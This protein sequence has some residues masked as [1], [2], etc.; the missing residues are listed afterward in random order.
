MFIKTIF[1]Q[2]N[3]GALSEWGDMQLFQ[4][5]SAWWSSLLDR[6]AVPCAL[7]TTWTMRRTGSSRTWEDAISD[8]SMPLV[9][10][11]IDS[12]HFHYRW[13]QVDSAANTYYSL[14][15]LTRSD[16]R[17]GSACPFV[18]DRLCRSGTPPQLQC[19]PQ[20]K[21]VSPRNQRLQQQVKQLLTAGISCHFTNETRCGHVQ[22]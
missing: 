21:Q 20:R 12:L 2:Y 4:T 6:P 22:S 14:S 15:S 3:T 9:C 7:P 5:S 13:R 19:S 16:F 11:Q 17:G 18:S 1:P 8:P 10:V